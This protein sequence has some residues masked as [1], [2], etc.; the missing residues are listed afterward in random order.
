MRWAKRLGLSVLLLLIVT[1]IGLAVWEPMSVAAPKAPPTHSYDATIARDEFG[2]PHIFGKTDADASYGLGYAHSEDDF[3]TIQEVIAMTRGRYGAMVGADGAKIDYV[4]HLLRSRE[5]ARRDYPNMPADVR[6]VLD[7]YAAGLNRYAEKHPDEIRLSKLFPVNGEDVATGFVLRSPFFFGL[8]EYIGRLSEGKGPPVDSPAPITP[9]GRDPSMNGSNAFAVAPKRMADGKTWLISNSHQPYEGQVA[10]YEAVMH[11]DEGLDMAG[12]LF[13]GS[14]F[15]LL[16][17][18]K[19]LGWTNTV[20]HPDLVDVYKLVLNGDGTQYRMDGKWLPLQ[21]KRVWLHIKYGPFT[22]PVPKTV[23]YSV[24]GPVIINKNGAFAIRYAG[25]DES[26]NMEQ[27]F[28]ITKAQD[29]AQWT[30]AMDIGGVAATNFIYADKTGRI[31][32]IYNAMFP[33]RKPGYNYQGVLPGDTSADMWSGS[34]GFAAMPK[35]VDP[36]SGFVTNANNTPFLSAG[37]GSEM[38]PADY[39]PMMGIERRLTN[40]GIR[41]VELMSADT[42]ITPEEMMTIKFDIGYSKAS[43]V[44]VWMAQIAALDLK[45]EPDLAK[46]QAL[47]GTWDWKSDGKGGA[48]TLAELMIRAANAANYHN[49]P[50][51]DPHK[52]LRIWVDYMMTHFNRIDLPLLEMQRLRRGTIDLPNDGGTDA[53]R[54]T[55]IWDKDQKDGKGRVKHGD[56][57]IM[58]MTW[59]KAGAV[60]SR[61]IQPYG[62]ATTRPKSPHYTDQMQMFVDHKFKDVWF[63]RDQLK[64]HITKEYRP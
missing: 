32:Y 42:S 51:P 33:P 37:A 17:H 54:A 48:D 31:A 43:Y 13:P 38:N 50:L 14:P 11:S 23:Y 29:W 20:N 30:K 58:L 16:G 18:N 61:S 5:T 25:I 41:A 44:G 59:D 57:F 4:G 22:L 53:L 34:Q 62:A 6:A 64:G 63:T 2:V 3:S 46:A 40:R 45:K 7:G 35:I 8:D 15:I 9:I 60:S 55:S 28:R 10:W 52:E 26:R 56:S 1:A 47:L 36:A 49:E 19:N 39:S 21:S 24:H 12:A 27:Y